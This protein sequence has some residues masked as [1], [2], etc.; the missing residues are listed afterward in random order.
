MT[1]ELIQFVAKFGSE[2][3]AGMSPLAAPMTIP[4]PVFARA[5]MM[6]GSVP[7]SLTF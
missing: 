4:I 3:K 6:A 7:Y 2:A 5:L 1:L